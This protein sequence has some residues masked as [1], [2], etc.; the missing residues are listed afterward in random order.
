MKAI[1]A[2]WFT[3]KVAID[4]I[5]EGGVIKK[6][7]EHYVVDA[8]SFTEAEKR[9][10][11]EVAQYSCGEF[12]V[13]DIKQAPFKEVFFVEDDAS[14]DDDK[15][16]KAKLQFIVI[17]EKTEKEKRSSVYY[18]VQAAS[19]RKALDNIDAVMGQSMAD[20]VQASVVETNFIDVFQHVA[21][22]D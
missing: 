17:D 8:Q 5:T 2:L 21:K 4:K 11:D 13:K 6:V 16:Y 7:T 15:W 22:K 14:T 12:E 19:L 10:T 9:I 18:L 3:C 1:Q 20:Y